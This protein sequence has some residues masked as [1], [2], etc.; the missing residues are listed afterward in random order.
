[1]PSLF[2]PLKESR[3]ESPTPPDNTNRATARSYGVDDQQVHAFKGRQSEG[4]KISEGGS[5]AERFSTK[6]ATSP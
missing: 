6:R 1:M 4:M 2:L 3:P 5:E